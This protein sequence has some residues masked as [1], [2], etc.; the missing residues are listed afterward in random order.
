MPIVNEFLDVFP[1]D[2]PGVA[3]L[4]EIDF[5]IDLE[6]DTK[7]ISIPFYRISVAELKELK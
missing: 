6:P 7:L 5:V 3:S 2:F 1:E 4:R